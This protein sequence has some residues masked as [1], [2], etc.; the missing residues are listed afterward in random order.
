MADEWQKNK[1]MP[2]PVK[3]ILR[4][5]LVIFSV[6]FV[7]A[8]GLVGAIYMLNYGP[9][10]SAREMFVLSVRETS[11][12]KFLAD[13]VLPSDVVE[14][15][16]MGNEIEEFD[17]VSNPNLIT[18]PEKN[19]Q[20]EEVEEK[21]VEI[22]P[23]RGVTYSGRM[24]VVKDPSRVKVGVC[25]N[26]GN[27]D[28]KGE[29]LPDMLDKYNAIGGVNAGGFDDPDGKGTGTI[30]EGFVFSG[31]QMVFGS[32]STE[33]VMVGFNKDNIMVVGKMTGAAAKAAGIR[34]A[35]A[36]GPVLVKDGKAAISNNTL[37]LNPRT[38]IGQRAD[39]AV[40]ILVI[41]GRQANSLGASYSDLVDVM[42]Q[43][44][45]IN[46]CNLDGGSSSAMYYEGEL[47]SNLST[48]TGGRRLPDCIYVEK[49]E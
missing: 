13:L 15:I 4:G 31:G 5:V 21:D 20:G 45:A 29:Y 3:Y 46:A 17:T 34:D 27:P 12:L 8:G 39:G 16:V 14:A 43:F 35:V 47:I 1:K 23:V 24:M 33:C 2:T 6:V 30:P 40:L 42:M 26:I 10:G 11:A 9:S 18:I 32:D 38:A 22:V 7:I 37:N 28:K 25:G 19:E 44:G 48:L 41:D 36:F 49:R